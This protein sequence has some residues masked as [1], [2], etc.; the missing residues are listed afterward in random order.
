[1]VVAKNLKLENRNSKG[2]TSR[3]NVYD[4]I[5]HWMN[6]CEDKQMVPNYLLNEYSESRW[7]YDLVRTLLY[8]PAGSLIREIFN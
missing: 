4:S 7:L 5:F 3:Y 2:N 6:Q 8:E 1:M